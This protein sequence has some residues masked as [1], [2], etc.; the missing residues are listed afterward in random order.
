MSTNAFAWKVEP[1]AGRRRAAA[2]LIMASKQPLDSFAVST[3]DPEQDFCAN[4]SSSSFDIRKVIL[5]DTDALREFLLIHIKSPQL[6]Y[7]ASDSDPIDSGGRRF[8]T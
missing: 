1:D 7:S 4:L 8:F 5:A 3:S 6:A 2:L